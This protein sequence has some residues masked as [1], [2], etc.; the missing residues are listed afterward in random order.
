MDRGNDF[1]ESGRSVR[2]RA[3]EKSGKNANIY[4]LH[5]FRWAY[6]QF[7]E[8]KKLKSTKPKYVEAALLSLPATLDETYE[9]ILSGI[10]GMFH[11]EALTLLRWLAFAQW[12]LTLGELAEATIINPAGDGIVDTYNRGHLE[13][14]LDILS[15]LVAVDRNDE[16]EERKDSESKAAS[17]K[18]TDINDAHTGWRIG[19]DTKVKL[20]HFSVKEY[21]ESKRILQSNAKN[22]YLEP[23]KDHR[24]LA[25]SCLTYIAYYSSSNDKTLTL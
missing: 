7:Q 4:F 20:A 19:K 16:D 23:A 10:Q 11:D 22:F 2:Y 13:D 14:T 15:G 18:D 8:L 1:T 17:S 21:L 24:F 6:C 9:R 5:R 12:P 25:Q 3:L